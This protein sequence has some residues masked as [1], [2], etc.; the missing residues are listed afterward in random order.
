[1]RNNIV[2]NMDGIAAGA[3]NIKAEVVSGYRFSIYLHARLEV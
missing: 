2:A 1:M 3:G